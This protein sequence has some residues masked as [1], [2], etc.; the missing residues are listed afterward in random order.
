MWE[1]NSGPLEEQPVPLTTKPSLQP[2]SCDF[3]FFFFP[4]PFLS[5]ALALLAPA[6]RFFI[7]FSLQ[8][9]VSHHVVAGI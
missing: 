3:L 8:I 4:L 1:L 6:H 9:V 5:L 7:C 2:S